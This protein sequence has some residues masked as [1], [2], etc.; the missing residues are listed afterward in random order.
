M[1]AG[2]AGCE[3]RFDRVLETVTVLIREIVGD[4]FFEECEIGLDSSFAEDI[5]MESTEVLQ[6][7][8]RLIE[9]YEDVDFIQWLADMDL[10]DLVALTLRNFVDFIASALEERE[11]V[12]H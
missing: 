2:D 11:A 6:F 7:G 5:E 9:T 12:G 3:G 1:G 4:E 10:D 8:E